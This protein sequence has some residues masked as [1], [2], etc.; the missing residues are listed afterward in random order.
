MPATYKIAEV[1]RRSGFNTSTLRY[2]EELGLV[3][4]AGR[5]SA[6]YRLYDDSSLA[7][8][9]FVSRAKQLGCTLEEITELATAWDGQ[10]CE[11]I[12]AR[13]RELVNNKIAGAQSRIAEMVALTAQLQHAAAALGA[14]TP[15]GPCDD[16]CGCAAPTV[17]AVADS[18]PVQLVA[19]PEPMVDPSIVCTLGAKAMA[20][21]VVQW[22]TALA[23]VVSRERIDGGVRLVLSADASLGALL[24]LANAEQDCCRFF[25][26]AMTIDSRGAALEVRA[27]AHATEIVHSLF[28]EPT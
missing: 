21:R 7:R 12:Q 16:D 25:R 20:A 11:P 17:D 27:P 15:D 18:A 28:G 14:H 19:E 4:P 2:Y 26:F 22:Q 8:L 9:A 3:P 24:E 1:A 23:D 6:G 13:L 5:T 10:R